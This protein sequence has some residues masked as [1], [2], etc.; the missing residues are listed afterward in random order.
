M[1]LRLLQQ[2]YSPT[3]E[4]I[5]GSSRTI[6]KTS[7]TCQLILSWQ[8]QQTPVLQTIV[9]NLQEHALH[10]TVG[11]HNLQLEKCN[12]QNTDNKNHLWKAVP[13]PD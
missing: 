10:K 3:K 2:A 1:P 12:T 5:F 9:D 13:L 8:I 7:G 6:K 4:E 11:A